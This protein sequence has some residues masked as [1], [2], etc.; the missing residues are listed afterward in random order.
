MKQAVRL[1]VVSLAVMLAM[2]VNTWLANRVYA[3]SGSE[4]LSE[5]QYQELQQKRQEQWNDLERR[6]QRQD[7]IGQRRQE[8]EKRQQDAEKRQREAERR[9]REVEK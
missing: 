9:L 2:P 7:N 5:Q 4:K 6:Q 3:Q 8:G 1:G